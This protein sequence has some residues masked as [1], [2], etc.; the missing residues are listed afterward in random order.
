MKLTEQVIK[1]YEKDN[2]ETVKI[3][4][5][6][7]NKKSIQQL[8]KKEGSNKIEGEIADGVTYTA[9]MNGVKKDN[10]GT[11]VIEIRSN[12]DSSTMNKKYKN[13][14]LKN[15][16]KISES[17]INEG[18][19]LTGSVMWTDRRDG[20]G[21]IKGDD[22]KEYYFDSSMQKDFKNINRKDKVEF[23][24]NKNSEGVLLARKISVTKP[25]GIKE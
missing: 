9:Y 25:S 14:I 11:F 5:T 10:M 12:V 7:T 24:P 17:E 23:S 8:F 3:A 13:D 2:T 18:K 16:F 6:D 1:M 21:I 22:E 19:T 15:V 20:N 4:V